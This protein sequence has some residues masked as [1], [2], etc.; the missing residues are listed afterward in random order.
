LTL[1][2]VFQQATR[3][4]SYKLVR[5]QVNVCAT[6]PNTN[7]T[8]EILNE[9]YQINE[10]PVTPKID[11]AGTALCGE[12]ESDKCPMGLTN[13][14]KMI[15][16]K[17][18]AAREDTLT[19]EPPCPGDGNLDKVVNLADVTN[20][21]YFSTNGVPSQTPNTPPNTSSWYDFNHDGSTDAADLKII[22][23]SFGTHCKTKN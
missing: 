19:S 14:Q 4:D 22:I 15:F 23:N 8:T 18:T 1:L 3:D 2:P 11:K 12:S 5:K 6:P 16:N 9:F 20:W 7:D 13:Q 10:D 17:L 21:F